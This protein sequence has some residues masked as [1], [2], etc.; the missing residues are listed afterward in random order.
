MVSRRIAAIRFFRPIGALFFLFLCTSGCGFGGGQMLYALGFGRT[1]KVKAE[2]KLTEN[3]IL[4]L[5]DDDNDRVHW[6]PAKRYLADEVAQELLRHKAA[7]QIIPQETIEALRQAHPDFDKR[8][9][10]EVGEMAGAEQVVWIQIQDFFAEEDFLDATEAAFV[11]A[12]V[13]VINVLEKEQ[14]MH[15]RIWPTGSSGSAVTASL[16]GAHVVQLK[17][18]DAICEELTRELAEKI[19]K[20]FY[21]HRLGDFEKPP[22]G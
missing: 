8:G 2:I 14:R 13:K 10:R 7:K 4:I 22:G 1:Q 17:K 20:F 18:K 16:T 12:T 6:P 9:C 5:V 15:V 11:Q 3:P 19:A 21:D